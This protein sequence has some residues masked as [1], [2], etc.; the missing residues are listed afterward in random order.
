MKKILKEFIFIF[1]L[2]TVAG[3]LFGFLKKI[4]FFPENTEIYIL[5]KKYPEIELINTNELFEIYGK[6]N[7]TIVDARERIFYEQGHIKGAINIPY[8]EF[9]INPDIFLKELDKKK[10]IVIYCEG[11]YCEASFRVAEGL[12]KN[13]FKNIGVYIGGY[14]EWER[15]GL[16]NE[17]I[18]F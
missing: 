9:E 4:E 13:G 16:P 6:E 14:P 12:F 10:K 8:D 5:S 17:K 2:S 3:I 18:S 11:G 7:L 1:L 15:K